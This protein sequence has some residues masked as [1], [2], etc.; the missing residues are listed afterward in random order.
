ML[1]QQNML[2]KTYEYRSVG[3]RPQRINPKQPYD[4]QAAALHKRTRKK[5]FQGVGVRPKRIN[6]TT[7]T[8][9]KIT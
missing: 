9:W 7:R 3:V 1:Y 4:E 8:T 6:Q 2:G 5:Q